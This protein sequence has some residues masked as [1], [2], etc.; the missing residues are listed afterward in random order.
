R[1]A[2]MVPI[3]RSRRLLLV[4]L[5]LGAA[6]ARRARSPEEAL[7]QVERAIV[8]GDGAALYDCLDER[9]R[10]SI[11]SAYQDQRLQRTIILGRY[12]EE[13]AARALAPLG[14]AAEADVSRY[15]ARVTAERHTLDQLRRRLGAAGGAPVR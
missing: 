11:D 4:T 6:C 3:S 15:F 2:K 1:W 5:L 10:W 14:A 7:T 12:P 13:E 8:A 9:T